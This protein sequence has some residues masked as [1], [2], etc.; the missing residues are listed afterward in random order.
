MNLVFVG[1]EKSIR[2]AVGGKFLI[3]KKREEFSFFIDVIKSYLNNQICYSFNENKNFDWSYFLRL[4]NLHKLIPIVYKILKNENFVPAP[5]LKQLKISAFKIAIKNDALKK[6]LMNVLD[7]LSENGIRAIP[8]KGISIGINY[9]NDIS[10]RDFIDL[11]IYVEKK[12]V[13]KAKNILIENG[14]VDYHPLSLKQEEN[15]LDAEYD[16]QLMH[17]NSNLKRPFMLEIHWAFINP[18]KMDLKFDYS[19]VLSMVSKDGIDNNTMAFFQHEYNLLIN[20]INGGVKD[21]WFPIR[22]LLDLM[23]ITNKVKD[24]KVIN[25]HVEKVPLKSV[26]LL[27]YQLCYELFEYNF[28]KEFMIRNSDDINSINPKT[29]IQNYQRMTS[30]HS[31]KKLVFYLQLLSGLRRKMH[32]ML[33]YMNYIITPNKYDKHKVY[34][35][36][37][38][39]IYYYQRIKRSILKYVFHRDLLMERALS[40]LNIK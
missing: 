10:L 29:H 27:G 16:Y 23:L 21:L 32:F 13:L 33:K 36:Y 28:P 20:M 38:F 26:F 39:G 22:H 18:N 31:I 4:S 14:F 24:W 5:I 40:K 8:F 19:S 1:A 9:Y 3:M 12:H 7:L 15:M 37:L 25:E 30:P 34:P 6:E 35:K 2:N 11:D 17:Y